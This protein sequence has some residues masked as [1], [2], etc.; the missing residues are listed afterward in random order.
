MDGVPVSVALAAGALAVLNPCAFPMLPA[1]LSFYVGADERDL[2][3]ASTRAVQG[4]LVALAVTAGFL[5]LFALVGLPVAY[6]AGAIADAVP[7]AGIVLGVALTLLGFAAVLGRSVKLRIANPLGP[8]RERGVAAMI[9]YGAGYGVASL[10]CTLPVFLALVGASVGA[11]DTLV[12][13]GAYGVGMTLML[14]ALAVGA[15]LLRDGLA[16]ALR[17]LLPH[18]TRIAGAL[19]VVAGAYLTYYW[20]RVRFGET[21]TLASD[22]VV[23]LVTRFSAEIQ[24]AAEAN[25]AAVVAAVALLLAGAMS[26]GLLAR[27][28]VH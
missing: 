16:R 27:R 28:R 22:P 24:A 15:S 3:R 6:G 2:P 26:V 23:G 5:G 8:R 10:G 13:F 7:W 20:A 21:G 25:A 17:R 18:M 12:V 11:G 4:V 19:L 1:L 9:A 14:S